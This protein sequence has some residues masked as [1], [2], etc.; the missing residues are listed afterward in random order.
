MRAVNLLPRELSGRHARPGR[1]G[2][3]V[4]PLAAG[5]A[6][7]TVVVAAALGGGFVMERSHASSAQRRLAAARAEL[8]RL[9]STQPAKTPG[10]HG[11][12]LSASVLSQQAPW[13]TALTSA[14]AGRVA[15]DGVLSELSRVV[16]ANVTVS[17][18]TLGGSSRS[19]TAA[20]GGSLSLAG[21]AYSEQGVVQLLSRLQLVPGL[22]QI[23][24]GPTTAA[25]KSGVVSWSL[26]ATIAA[27]AAPPSTPVTGAAS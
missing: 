15:W 12:T 2:R 19:K 4:D 8:A 3:R 14:L 16:P 11:P 23:V 20:G 27:P 9:Q 22:S 17:T 21:T 26:T 13:Q 7:L 25:G 18:V 10:T 5:G 24:L 1:G 6:V